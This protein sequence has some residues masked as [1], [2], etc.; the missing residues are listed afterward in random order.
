METTKVFVGGLTAALF[1]QKTAWVWGEP[2]G[3]PAAHLLPQPPGL[4]G[5]VINRLE[6]VCVYAY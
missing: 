1:L 4:C 6:L 3:R 2:P 5:D